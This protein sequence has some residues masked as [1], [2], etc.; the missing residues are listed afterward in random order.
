MSYS[1]FSS[2]EFKECEYVQTQKSH[3]NR[4]CYYSLPVLW[5]QLEFVECLLHVNHKQVIKKVSNNLQS[6]WI[7]CQSFYKVWHIF[8]FIDNNIL[9]Q[10]DNR[11]EFR[12]NIHTL[13]IFIKHAS[14]MR[15]RKTFYRAKKISNLTN[16]HCQTL[17]TKVMTH[18]MHSA[19]C[20]Q[21]YHGLNP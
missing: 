19:F 15:Q 13:F 8:W 16:V 17:A 14:W 18:L 12:Q 6:P 5:L 3:S 20:Q 9:I 7:K 2:L 11:M 1:P 10:K 4:W 21:V